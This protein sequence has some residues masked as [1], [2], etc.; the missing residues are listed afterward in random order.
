MLVAENFAH[1]IQ[2]TFLTLRV[3]LDETDLR[4]NKSLQPEGTTQHGH[5]LAPPHPITPSSPL[6]GQCRYSRAGLPQQAITN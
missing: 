6:L 5:P 1:W 3:W 2:E 4:E